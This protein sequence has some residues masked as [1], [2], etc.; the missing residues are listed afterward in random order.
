MQTSGENLSRVVLSG[1]S[2]ANNGNCNYLITQH[3]FYCILFLPAS[4][5]T[6]LYNF[7]KIVGITKNFIYR[8]E[9]IKHKNCMWCDAEYNKNNEWSRNGIRKIILAISDTKKNPQE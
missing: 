6:E 2:D 7:N 3:V 1:L 4:R 8:S 5:I 9:L